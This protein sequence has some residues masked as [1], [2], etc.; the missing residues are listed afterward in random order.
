MA[1]VR[2]RIVGECIIE[3]G[4]RQ[5]SPDSPHL[6]ALL[7]YLAI[8]RGRAVQRSELS[9]LLFPHCDSRERSFHSL[10]QLLYRL[11]KL[12]VVTEMSGSK[13]ILHDESSESL[14]ASFMS[15]GREAR[16]RRSAQSLE[17][18]PSYDPDI[19][20]ALAEWI[21]S[22]RASASAAVRT[23]LLEDF[24]I[25]RRECRWDAVIRIG[26]LLRHIDS[27]NERV[28]MGI[29]EAL[30]SEGR[31]HEA[32]NELDSF[33]IE[34]ER[35]THEAREVRKLR[36]RIEKAQPPFGIAQA[37][38][39]GRQDT[40]LALQD[41]WS[42]AIGNRPQMCV[43]LG[44]PGIGKTRLATEFSAH[45]L[46]NGWQS[47]S[48]RCEVSD[49]QRPLSAF[50]QLVPQLRSMRGSLGASPELQRSLDLLSVERTRPTSLE[51][52]LLEATRAEIPL[53]L[54]DLIDAVTS[55]HPLLLTIDDAHLLDTASWAILCSL[56]G[57]RGKAPLM[58]VCC[59]RG[60]DA[61]TLPLNER[62]SSTMHCLTPL[63]DGDSLLL[64]MELASG[65]SQD[66]KYIRWCLTQASGNPF[67]LHSLA[68]HEAS[69]P[70]DDLLPFDIRNLASSSYFSLDSHSRGL[71]EACLLLGRFASVRRVQ[72]I[73]D[74]SGEVLVAALRRLEH[75][76]LLTFSAGE[77]R[78][79]HA[80]LE[81]A[82]RSLVPRTVAA[83]LHARVAQSLEGDYERQAY[84]VPLAWAAAE[85]WI[86]AG[87]SNAAVRLLKHCAAQ[88]A[89]VGE[90]Q[91]AA[92]TLLK[93]SPSELSLAERAS[94]QDEI[95]SYAEAGGARILLQETLR[96]RIEA[97]YALGARNCDIQELEFKYIEIAFQQGEHPGPWL[98]ALMTLLGNEDARASLRTRAGIC[99][100]VASDLL[101]D[102][103]LA[104]SSYQ[105]LRGVLPLLPAR[106]DLGRRAEIIYETVFGDQ[107][108]AL[109]VVGEVL[110]DYPQPDLAQS[111]LS[112]RHE[113]SYAL[114]RLGHFALAKPV[115]LANYHF[116]FAHHVLT[117]AVYA[118]M[119][120]ADNAMCTGDLPQAAVWLEKAEGSLSVD[121]LRTDGRA[122][123]IYSTKASLALLTGRLD[124]ADA[125]VNAMC[126]RYPIVGTPR[127][128]SI[129]AAL[130]VRIKA[131]RGMALASDPL[132]G[133]LR[134]AYSRGAHLGGQD[135]IVEALWHVFRSSGDIEGA[136]QLL[137][138][139]LSRHRREV[140]PTEAPLRLGTAADA[141]WRNYTVPVG[142]SYP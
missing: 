141:V 58:V 110:R 97:A 48:Y 73:A 36:A 55:E 9:A 106:S 124:E 28:V 98:D 109:D 77:L 13:V 101:L 118:L 125:L 142:T 137:S 133:E 62:T 115:L 6:F 119:L 44:A 51:P 94:L 41:V 100:L 18:L 26:L 99:L 112:A 129:A 4:G 67:Y 53:A 74:I 63:S 93:I 130:K 90:P 57:S 85:S 11:H 126:E 49:T 7:L 68:R 45:L 121:D 105:Q 140:T 114:S 64:L 32:I 107:A 60:N 2:L 116:M 39:R 92:N 56:C 46:L 38:F 128:G 14:V 96:E 40:L 1:D 19:S 120:L 8:E 104:R 17:I 95:I 12:G 84:S 78:L 42:A 61:T 35:G 31:A 83:A 54:I 122:A 34:Q 136:S 69:A 25:V 76:G 43:L 20:R 91:A 135:H 24:R 33:L 131:A 123:G 72:E 75:G 29:A 134:D 117:E 16:S 30:F 21:D 50:T 103:E 139:Y 132:A 5:V 15:A 89:A 88:A 59:C 127:F 66:E 47:L 27:A 79:S 113:A 82:I 70:S 37:T 108:R 138:D 22:V 86:A 87:D 80:L 10:R 65:H 52:A 81:E 71:L 102:E 3:V 111:S 23:L